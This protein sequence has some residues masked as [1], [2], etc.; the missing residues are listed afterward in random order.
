[1]PKVHQQ[2][3]GHEKHHAQRRQQREPRDR[4]ELLHAEHVV[5]TRNGESAGHQARQVRVDDDHHAP[6][7]DSLVRVN[8]T[9]KWREFH[10][11]TSLSIP[12]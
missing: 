4:L 2:G 7:D 6:L 9:G 1:M 3:N 8:V 12:I 5:K 11:D 10:Q